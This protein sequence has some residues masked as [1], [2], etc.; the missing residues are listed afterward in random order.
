M[1][2]NKWLDFVKAYRKKHPGQS[3]KTSLKAASVEYKK[4]KSAAPKKKKPKKKAQKK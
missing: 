1:A 3:L 2:G 4:T